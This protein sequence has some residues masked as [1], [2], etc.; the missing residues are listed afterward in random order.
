M[1]DQWKAVDKRQAA[2]HRLECLKLACGNAIASG[3]TSLDADRIVADAETYW[4]FVRD[5]E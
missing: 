5:Q 3:G 2:Q 4:E 1:S